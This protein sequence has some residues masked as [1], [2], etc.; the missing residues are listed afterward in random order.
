MNYT[1]DNLKTGFSFRVGKQETR[2]EKEKEKK[3]E[4]KKTLQN[5][6]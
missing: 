4:E 3:K 1:L 2:R 5:F 6:S